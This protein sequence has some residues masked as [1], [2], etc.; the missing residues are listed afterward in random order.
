MST[1]RKLDSDQRND[2]RGLAERRREIDNRTREKTETLGAKD[3]LSKEA[4]KTKG[5][6]ES[7]PKLSTNEYF[8]RLDRI[9]ERSSMRH[10]RDFDPTR[11]QRLEDFEIR[12]SPIAFL[13]RQDH[14]GLDR[15]TVKL[16]KF[17]LEA[18]GITEAR[19]LRESGLEDT[20]G[21]WETKSE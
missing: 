18:H 8:Q 6:P 7:L 2:S 1:D 14:A 10:L 9:A 15:G 4:A 12:T 17:S 13:R 16:V 3:A 21:I 11:E 20:W 19:D 5:A